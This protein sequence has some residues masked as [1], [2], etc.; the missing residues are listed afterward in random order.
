VS[1]VNMRSFFLLLPEKTEKMVLRC[2][3][4]VVFLKFLNEKLN[5]I[6][7]DLVRLMIVPAFNINVKF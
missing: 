1:W 6:R 3:Y 5:L 7:R 2:T 4:C